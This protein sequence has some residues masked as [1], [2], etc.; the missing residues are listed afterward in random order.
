MKCSALLLIHNDTE[1]ATRS[2]PGKLFEYLAT[3]VPVVSICRS[4]GDLSDL[5]DEY[6]LPHSEHD[7]DMA[8]VAQLSGTLT[9]KSI[10]T[11]PF[12]REELTNAL[13][14]ELEELTQ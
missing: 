5:L 6:G 13:I 7:D 2:I 11:H 1:S 10:D 9:Q 3:G 14:K 12:K 4:N 8:A